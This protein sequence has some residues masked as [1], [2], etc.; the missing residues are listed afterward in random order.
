MDSLSFSKAEIEEIV[1]LVRFRLYNQG[2]PHGPAAVR[3]EIE[4]LELRPVPSRSA[5]QRILRRLGLT[6]GRTRLYP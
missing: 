1:A 5:I 3:R 2:R 6:H 4:S